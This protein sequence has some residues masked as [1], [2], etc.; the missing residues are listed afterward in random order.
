MEFFSSGERVFYLFSLD[1]VAVMLD[2][3]LVAVVKPSPA[4][5]LNSAS[6]K[7]IDV[8]WRWLRCPL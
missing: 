8:N 6:L 7:L 1:D 2:R 5:A 4:S 3:N